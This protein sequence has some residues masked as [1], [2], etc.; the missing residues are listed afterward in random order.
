MT[1]FSL[2]DEGEILC[3]FVTG[4]FRESVGSGKAM[5]ESVGSK[6]GSGMLRD[7]EGCSEELAVGRTF[8]CF[9]LRETSGSRV[10]D[11]TGVS[12]LA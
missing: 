11:L 3:K 2:G 1:L 6:V 5:T 12:W 7:L 8:V 9:F 4:M 10:V